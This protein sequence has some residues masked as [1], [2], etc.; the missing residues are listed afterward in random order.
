MPD[1]KF[2]IQMLH[3]RVM[4]R[5]APVDEERRSSAG[6]VIPAT[7]KMTNR[8]AWGEVCGVGGSVRTVKVGNKVLFHPDDQFEVE[9]RNEIYLVMRERDLHAIASEGPEHGTGLY[10]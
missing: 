1:A 8:L 6:I 3:D 4:V 2:E 7:V 5:V 10:L 9:V